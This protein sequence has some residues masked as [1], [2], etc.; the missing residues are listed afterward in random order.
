M[1]GSD[2]RALGPAPC[3]QPTILRRQVGGLSLHAP[4]RL[5]RL[6][7][8]GTQPGTSLAGTSALVFASALLVAG[9][10]PH[11]RGE[12]SRAGEP[13]HV[14]TNLSHNHLSCP[15]PDP[16]PGLQQDDFHRPTSQSGSNFGAELVHALVECG[17]MGP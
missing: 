6:D 10:Q 3:G 15:L 14:G 9:T 8:G 2:C 5:S 12:M 11:P 1:R 16:W 13:G 4:S 7:Q 17:N